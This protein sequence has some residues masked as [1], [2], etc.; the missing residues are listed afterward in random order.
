MID[1]LRELY[2]AELQLK[3]IIEKMA[4]QTSNEDLRHSFEIASKGCESKI[5]KIDS[6]F[7][8]LSV[9]KP[10]RR[11]HIMEAIGNE[12]QY[13]IDGTRDAEVLDAG[14][15]ALAQKAKHYEI[16]LYGTLREYANTLDNSEAENLLAEILL[17]EKEDDRALTEK[18]RNG[19]NLRASDKTALP[20]RFASTGTL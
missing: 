9:G 2:S 18:A 1:Q 6:V 14:F 12:V 3:V 19:I 8:A 4:Y 17:E 13:F 7:S 16:A 10:E 5:Q 15:I 11:A 20:K